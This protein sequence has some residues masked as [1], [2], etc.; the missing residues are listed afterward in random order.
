MLPHAKARSA[1]RET[2]PP[3]HS[4]VSN[5][6]K[7]RLTDLPLLCL[8]PDAAAERAY[9]F[10]SRF[11]GVV[12]YP[13]KAEAHPQVL[14]AIASGVSRA[15]KKIAFDVASLNEIQLA[16][17]LFPS[18]ALYF[19]HPFKKQSWIDAAYRDF[20]VRH[21]AV[22]DPLELDKFLHGRVPRDAVIFVRV[23]F[24]P[25]R[26]G[27]EP[28]YKV[29]G[30]FGAS[31]EEA[32]S[33]LRIASDAGFETGLAFHVGSQCLSA[34]PWIDSI[35][36]C[37]DIVRRA[38]VRVSHLD[39]G[40]G[41]P[42]IYSSFGAK[43]HR[44]YSPSADTIVE[45]VAERLRQGDVASF[46]LIAEPGRALV[47]DSVS[48]VTQIIGRKSSSTMGDRRVARPSLYIDDGVWSLLSESLTASA[49]WPVRWHMKEQPGP[50]TPYYVGGVTCDSEDVLAGEYNLPH[51]LGIGDFIEFGSVGAYGSAIRSRFNGF[52]EHESVIIDEPFVASMSP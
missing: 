42:G 25:L 34:D 15:G 36:R 19:M 32:I 3:H 21:F 40:G 51:N 5:A 18:A 14:Q 30:K 48:V 1:V 16:K 11:P 7:A 20:H 50:L 46:E 35:D 27:P 4:T 44:G 41:F 12:A 17:S 37:L 13:V 38:S 10:A 45:Q 31:S 39:V 22:D 26:H 49:V 9:R 6:I 2:D 29:S 24:P 52:G 43:P 8:R 47:F 33:M 28:A 23:A